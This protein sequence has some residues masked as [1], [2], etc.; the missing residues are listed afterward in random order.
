MQA[1]PGD[2]PALMRRRT[3]AGALTELYGWEKVAADAQAAKLAPCPRRMCCAMTRRRSSHVEPA[4]GALTDSYGWGRWRRMQAASWRR[5]KAAAVRRHSGC[6][7]RPWRAAL[8]DR[9]GAGAD[10]TYGWEKV[11]ADA[12]AAKLAQTHQYRILRTGAGLADAEH[13]MRWQRPNGWLRT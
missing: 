10:R 7:A 2:A 9:T 3:G 6:A 11:A 1:A 5:L 8:R 13:Q 4:Q 12:Q